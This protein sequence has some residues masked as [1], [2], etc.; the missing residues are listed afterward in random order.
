MR[1]IT[2]PLMTVVTFD[3]HDPIGTYDDDHPNRRRVRMAQLKRISREGYNV[4]QRT[5]GRH[6]QAWVC[7]SCIAITLPIPGRSK[8]TVNSRSKRS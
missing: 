8:R 1:T 7:G 4:E 2:R 3:I 6:G 5:R